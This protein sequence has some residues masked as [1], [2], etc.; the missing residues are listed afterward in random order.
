MSEAE[1]GTVSIPAPGDGAECVG[2]AAPGPR[3]RETPA[4]GRRSED[5]LPRGGRVVFCDFGRSKIYALAESGEQVEMFDSLE[6]MVGKLRP[7]MVIID[8]LPGRLQKTA[9]EIVKTG[10]VFL[11][12]KSL[13]QLSEERKG[14]GVKKSDEN[15]VKLLR[16]LFHR[17]PEAFQPL[18]TS[19]SELE[20]RAL[21]ELWVELTRQKKAARHARTTTED[22]VATEAHKTLRRLIDVL[23]K[24]IHEKAMALQ[25]YKKAV[26]ELGLRGPSL[27]YIISHDGWALTTLARDKLAVR[28]AV[29]QRPYR[30]R[31]LRSQLLILLAKSAVLNK[32]PRYRKIYQHYR[33]RGKKHWP[34][35]LRVAKR[36]LRDLRQLK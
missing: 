12:L 3:G 28:Y 20:V 24:R 26:E 18:L 9:A 23:A 10:I 4:Q 19:P 7:D 31:P 11:R 16:E 27:A 30:K 33:Q 1:A 34:A 17:R 15:D 25:L 35:I 8:G 2:G 36:I 21:T 5:R 22:P 29:I 32:H 14:K 6:D 13:G